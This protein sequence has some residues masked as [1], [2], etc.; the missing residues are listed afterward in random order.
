MTPRRLVLITRRFWPLVGGAERAMAGLAQ[1]FQR[2]GHQVQVVTAQWE[3]HWPSELKHCEIDVTR[4]PHPKTRG[5]GTFRYMT[6]LKKWLRQHADEYDAALVSMLK[7]DAHVT[8]KSLEKLGKP[9]VIRAEGSG[10]TGDC[11]FH[12]TARFGGRMKKTSMLAD[13]IIAPS[14]KVQEELLESGFADEQVHF[15]A[16]GVEISNSDRAQKLV[17]RR[18]L[19]EAHPILTVES[20]EPLVVYTGRMDMQKGLLDLVN[21]WKIVS[22]TFPKGRL[23]L[24]GEGP[25]GRRIW[26]TI[27]ETRQTYEIVM[28]GTF[29]DVSDLLNAADAFVLPSYQEG[30]S[31]SL[32]EAMAHELPVVASDIPG[33]RDLVQQD[34]GFLFPPGNVESLAE[35]LLAALQKQRIANEYAANAKSFVSTHYS[36]NKMAKEHL[37]IIAA[38]LGETES[39]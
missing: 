20:G 21:A 17:S 14:T 19:A 3:P 33:N 8:V 24:V 10:P 2:L 23:W 37:K 13:S 28:P 11:A 32:L 31:L 6:R 26:D 39:I 4:L 35:A 36:L 5:W 18:S 7:H 27:R 34:R 12:K 29:D 1:E 38:A 22:Q 15:V 25:D 16:N 9:T 30:M